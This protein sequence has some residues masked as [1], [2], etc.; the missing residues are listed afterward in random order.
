MIEERLRKI[1][2]L[3]EQKVK[4][5]FKNHKKDRLSFI[6]LMTYRAD[7]KLEILSIILPYCVKNDECYYKILE[8]LGVQDYYEEQSNY[9]G[10]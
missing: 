6:L 10:E 9:W 7:I 2:E 1:D 3:I 5:F 4:Q 8:F